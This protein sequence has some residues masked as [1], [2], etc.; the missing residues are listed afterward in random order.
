MRE[1]RQ[2]HRRRIACIR[3]F[4]IFIAIAVEP[5][6]C[7]SP[8]NKIHACVRI[9]P[10]AMHRATEDK[11]ITII[12]CVKI[13]LRA[14]FSILIPFAVQCSLLPVVLVNVGVWFSVECVFDGNHKINRHQHHSARP[15]HRTRKTFI[16]PHIDADGLLF[17]RFTEYY[18]RICRRCVHV[19]P[20]SYKTERT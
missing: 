1:S 20:K 3:T 9:Y 15:S 12:E 17:S 7:S 2:W 13:H 6:V 10:A 14:A 16:S 18:R 4:V 19:S 5:I 11:C 8:A